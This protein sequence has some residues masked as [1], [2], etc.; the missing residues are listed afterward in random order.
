[1]HIQLEPKETCPP[2]TGKKISTGKKIHAKKAQ[3]PLQVGKKPGKRFVLF[4]KEIYSVAAK[5]LLT[6]FVPFLGLERQE[7][8]AALSCFFLARNFSKVRTPRPLV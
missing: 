3:G 8:A 4:K 1:M 6:M 5:R 2:R 7:F